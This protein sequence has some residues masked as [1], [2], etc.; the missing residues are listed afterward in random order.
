M[1]ESYGALT[2]IF[3][4]AG[5]PLDPVL[6]SASERLSKESGTSVSS[7]QVLFKWLIQKGVVVVTCVFLS[8][9][10]SLRIRADFLIRRTSSKVSRIKEALSTAS[11]PDLTSDEIAAI[12]TEGS[13]L[14]KSALMYYV[15]QV[16]EYKK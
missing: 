2:P 5:G 8:L 15:K 7:G 9:H 11:L 1:I 12:E 14:H 3:R 6:V 13:K 16:Q 4:A 10:F